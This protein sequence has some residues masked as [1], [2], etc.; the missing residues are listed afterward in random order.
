MSTRIAVG[1]CLLLDGFQLYFFVRRGGQGDTKPER[2]FYIKRNSEYM[3]GNAPRFADSREP[4]RASGP[5]EFQTRVT[6]GNSIF[7]RA[8]LLRRRSR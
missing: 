6:P 5:I 1:I 2:G 4:A 3:L 7:V 8:F